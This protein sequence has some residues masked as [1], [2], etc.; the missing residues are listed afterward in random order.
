M[1]TAWLVI[2]EFICSC[3]VYILIYILVF[4]VIYSELFI[5]YLY[6][7]ICAYF[8]SCAAV[9]PEFKLLRINKCFSRLIF[10]SLQ[11]TVVPFV[12]GRPLRVTLVDQVVPLGQLNPAG[13]ENCLSGYQQDFKAFTGNI[14]IVY[15]LFFIKYIQAITLGPRRLIPGGPAGPGGPGKPLSP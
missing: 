4:Y 11:V 3:V 10:Q 5:L 14:F 8:C 15:F 7:F 1:C 6:L 12:P 13:R 9:T 2:F